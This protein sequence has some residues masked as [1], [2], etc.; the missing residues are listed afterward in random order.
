MVHTSRSY[1]YASYE[2]LGI[3]ECFPKKL[4][5]C[6][7]S[8]IWRSCWHIRSIPPAT[9]PSPMTLTVVEGPWVLG[10]IERGTNRCFPT[11]CPGNPRDELTLLRFIHQFFLPG[12]TIIADC[13]FVQHQPLSTWIY[14]H[15]CQPLRRFYNPFAGGSCLRYNSRVKRESINDILW[16]IETWINTYFL[17]F[18]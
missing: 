16:P 2:E 14:L 9:Y 4:T 17:E 15:G 7:A 10:G 11:P 18:H 6:S 12:T 13:L 3:M 8:M 1:Q 5:V